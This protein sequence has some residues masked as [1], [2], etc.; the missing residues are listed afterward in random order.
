MNPRILIS[1]VF[2]AFCTATASAQSLAVNTDGSTANA[3]AL[4]D[5]KSTSKGIL[6]PRMSKTERNAI[7]APATGLL[8]FQNAPDSTGFYYY[9]GSSWVWLSGS[10]NAWSTT[11]NAGTTPASNFLGTT[12][13]NA[14]VFRTNN[15]EGMRLTTNNELGI[16][17]STPN[18]SYGFARLEIASEGYGTPVDLL[19]RNAVNDAGYAPG[20]IL[21]HARGTLAAP[22]TV[23]NGDYQAAFTSLNYDGSTYVQSAAIDMFTDGPVSTNKVSSRLQFATRDTAG[24]Y[25]YR[26]TLK[27]N[28]KLGI[29]TTNPSALTHISGGNLL[30]SGTHGSSPAIEFSGAGSKMFFYPRKSAIRAGYVSGTQWDDSNIGNFTVG[31]GYNA[32]AKSDYSVSIGEGNLAETNPFAVAIGR[33]NHST[34]FASLAMG[35]FSEASG[36]Y[37]SS[38]GLRDT[39]SAFGASSLGGYNKVSG[40]H[41]FAAGYSNIVTSDRGTALGGSNTVNGLIALA[42]GSN[43]KAITDYSISIGEGNI[44]E[45]NPFAV[46]IGRQNHSIGFA[47]LAMGHF[48]EASGDYSSS[49]GLRDTVSGYGASAA[50]SYNKVSG[51]YGHATGLSNTVNGESASATGN[52]NY[53]PSYGETTI[54]NFATQYAPLNPT[55]VN[56]ADRVFTVGNGTGTGSRSDALVILKSGQTGIATSTPNSTLQVD[57][58]I[59][60]GVSMGIAGN[61]IGTPTVI[62]T[63]KAYLGLSPSGGNIYYELPDPTTCT[64]R[65]YYIRNNDNTNSAWFRAPGASLLCPGSG[66]CLGAG[67]YYELKA[68][69]T[70]KSVMVISDGINWSVF[71]M[72]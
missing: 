22:L 48:S 23:I 43:S 20:V 72:D 50:G 26:M 55:G 42:L 30:V 25:A 28:G 62:T 27:S 12:D 17:T 59:A 40:P 53:A 63:Q 47:S 24:N 32:Q 70:V 15:A 45:T 64:G 60:V 49:V 16:G 19:I 65:I 10:N 57:G 7:A 13:N 29:G 14:L 58:T 37:S 44:A 9:N 39:V 36:D 35:H 34:G 71:K 66:T 18:S 31:L 3:S 8:I 6:I 69:V 5:V 41:G 21:Q 11:G 56:A 61:A 1:L 54:G 2:F 4:L 52:Y 46:A 33:Q 67:V 51:A 38:I 68:T